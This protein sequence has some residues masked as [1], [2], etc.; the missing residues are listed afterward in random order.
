MTEGLP[1]KFTA[2]FVN[3]IIEDWEQEKAEARR[4][5]RVNVWR[6]EQE[7]KRQTST[8]TSQTRDKNH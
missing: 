4:E 5:M 7:V 8:C 3:D 6:P 2:N 1:E